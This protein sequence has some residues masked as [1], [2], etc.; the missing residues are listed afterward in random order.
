MVQMDK[1]IKNAGEQATRHIEYIDMLRVLSMISVVFLHTAAGS[2]RADIGSSVWHFSNV[3]TALM[4]T[5]VPIFFMISGAV[6]LGNPKT[7]DIGYTLRHRLPKVLVPFLVWSLVAVA[8]YAALS[9]HS[10]GTVDYAAAVKRL[11]GITS[12]PTTVHLWFMYVLIPLY[13]LSPILKKLVDAM[14][15]RMVCYVLILWVLFSSVFPTLAA[16][17]PSHFKSFFTFNGSFNLNFL[18]GYAGYFLAGYYLMNYE[19]RVSKK[20]LT[21]IILADTLLISMGTWWKTI[22]AGEYTEVF[23]SY[24]KIFMLVL[25]VAIFML[26]KELFKDRRLGRLASSAVRVLSGLSFG[27]YLV[28]NLLVDLISRIIGLWPAPSIT[29]LVGCGLAVLLISMICIFILSRLK[30]FCFVFT[31]MKYKKHM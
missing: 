18:T 28:H 14:D 22:S 25:S 9:F 11:A 31:G 17:L 30:P 6:L 26:A 5:S 29:V 21:I 10:N 2:L 24:S 8:Y 1:S 16:L 12:Q 4:S 27:I 19:G 23:K 3:I 20:L 7:A 13:I 15:R